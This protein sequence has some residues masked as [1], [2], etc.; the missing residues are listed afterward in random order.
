MSTATH[1]DEFFAR[2]TDFPYNPA[3]P[4]I[5][6]FNRLSK[7][8]KWTA[9]S[10]EKRAARRAFRNAMVMQFNDF[11]G[12]DVNDIRSWHNLCQ[13][14]NIVPVPEGLGA[15]KKAV[16]AVYVNLVDLVDM[17]RTGKVAQQF[18]SEKELSV[19]SKKTEK[20]FPKKEAK[21]GGVLRFLLRHIMHPREGRTRA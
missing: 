1:I 6:E 21:A 10:S 4:V 5:T 13:V 7:F 3:T 2:Y 20:I 11:F 19:Y 8:F 18:N 14:L 17:K 15:C 12:T 16:K 9:K